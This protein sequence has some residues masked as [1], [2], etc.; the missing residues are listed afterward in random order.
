MPPSPWQRICP[1]PSDVPRRVP[2][3]FFIPLLSVQINTE[4]FLWLRVCYLVM[5]RNILSC[6]GPNEYHETEKRIPQNRDLVLR[7]RLVLYSNVWIGEMEKS[8]SRGSFEGT[9]NEAEEGIKF[10]FSLQ[11]PR[12]RAWMWDEHEVIRLAICSSRT[13]WRLLK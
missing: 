8:C 10:V 6:E 4:S 12:G 11:F 2:F 5:P 1:A 9:G 13:L 7:C 3:S